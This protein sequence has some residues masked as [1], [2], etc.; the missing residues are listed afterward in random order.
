MNTNAMNEHDLQE[1]LRQLIDLEVSERLSPEQRLL[2]AVLRQ[3]VLDYFDDDPLERLSAALY[4]TR[5]PLYRLTLHEFGLPDNLLPDGV[6]LTAFRRKRRREERGEHDPLELETLVRQLS[7]MQL[8]I[9]LS[10]GLLPLPATTRAISLNSGVTRSTA[11]VTLEQLAA[12][13]LAVRHDDTGRAT[14]SL[15][16]EVRRVLDEMWGRS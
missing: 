1:R 9:V 16:G 14:W 7:G 12:Q 3:A 10:M 5:S 11:L 6:D 4:F 15:P 8:K 2:L 13:G